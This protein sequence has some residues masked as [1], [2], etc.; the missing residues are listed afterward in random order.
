MVNH[1]VVVRHGF[2]LVV[3]V[4]LLPFFSWFCETLSLSSAGVLLR[5]TQ[6]CWCWRGPERWSRRSNRRRR[7]VSPAV[8][9]R[10]NKVNMQNAIVCL[11]KSA[12]FHETFS[13]VIVGILSHSEDAERLLQ[14][15]APAK[16]D[17][18][19]ISELCL[20]HRT[21]SVATEAADSL[22]R[23]ALTVGYSSH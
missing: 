4:F 18:G 8:V 10:F 21:S 3:V 2:C 17:T 12:S 13:P 14:C 20:V 23:K 6:L 7:K 19:W 9:I 11:L 22:C 16:L 5:E 15:S 1:R